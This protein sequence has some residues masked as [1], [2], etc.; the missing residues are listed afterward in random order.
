MKRDFNGVV[1]TGS[2]LKR[3][4]GHSTYQVA[5]LSF[6]TTVESFQCKGYRFQIYFVLTMLPNHWQVTLL[7]IPAYLSLCF[8]LGLCWFI[9]VSC[10]PVPVLLCPLCSHFENKPEAVES[11]FVFSFLLD[12]PLLVL[13]LHFGFWIS[14]HHQ[15]S[16]FV[17]QPACLCFYCNLHLGPFLKLLAC[18]NHRK[19]YYLSIISVS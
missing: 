8:P 12:F 13:C 18:K 3:E 10:F 6:S 7:S 17:G 1:L 4:A 14:T 16:L 2:L 5:T 9:C 11:S 19:I 15:S